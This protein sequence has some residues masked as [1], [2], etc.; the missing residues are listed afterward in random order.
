LAFESIGSVNNVTLVDG[1]TRNVSHFVGEA[2]WKEVTLKAKAE[3][4]E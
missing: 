1:E 3:L 4:V 2:F